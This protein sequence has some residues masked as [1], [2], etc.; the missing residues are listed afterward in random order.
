MPMGLESTIEPGDEV[1]V[2]LTLDDGTEVD[3]TAT[4]KEYTGAEETYA[5]ES[6]HEGH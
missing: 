5:P 3:F 6:G 1:A 2:T 4:A